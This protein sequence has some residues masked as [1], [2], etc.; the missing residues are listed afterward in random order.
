MSSSTAPT[1]PSVKPE[2][3]NALLALLEWESP[4]SPAALAQE[5]GLSHATVRRALR[6]LTRDGILTLQYDSRNTDCRR[7]EPVGFVRYPILTVLELTESHFL[8]RLGDTRGGS[9]YAALHPR[10]GFL[11]PEDDL[12]LLMNRV[13]TVLRAGVCHLPREIPLQAP[14]L[15]LPD[16]DGAPHMHRLTAVACR[17]LEIIPTAVMTLREA[18]ALELG[19][20]PVARGTSS[21]LYVQDGKT[22]SATLL[23]RRQVGDTVSPLVQAD[24][25]PDLTPL[26]L[27]RIRHDPPSSAARLRST[28]DFLRDLCRY[29]RPG[30]VVLETDHPI[31][32]SLPLR[33]A[34][35]E[36]IPLLCHDH[37]LN[38]PSL[39]HLGALRAARQALWSRMDQASA[40]QSVLS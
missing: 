33:Q 14:V 4:R 22:T 15:L 16:R 31:E 8:W 29:L 3:R 17:E 30:C 23:I 12:A 21:V 10:G 9:V 32:D 34:L 26:L 18:A 38:D 35:P 11:P 28:G 40:R 7:S 25:I 13:H 1:V 5:S 37:A 36:G 20:H 2:S 6:E 24:H 39:A 27:D 19:Y